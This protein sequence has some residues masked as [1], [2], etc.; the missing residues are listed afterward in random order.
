MYPA[1]L[2]ALCVICQDVT[3][4]PEATAYAGGTCT[5]PDDTQHAI[6]LKLNSTL[7]NYTSHFANI[8][9]VG[10]N[11]WLE[12]VVVSHPIYVRGEEATNVS[13]KNVTCTTCPATVV[14]TGAATNRHGAVPVNMNLTEV[15]GHTFSV[16][17]A[18]TIGLVT[19]DVLSDPIIVQ[20]V[21][22][23]V[24]EVVGCNTTD[25]GVLLSL[26]GD[27]YVLNFFD[28]PP[29]KIGGLVFAVKIM[30]VVTVSLLI[31]AYLSVYHLWQE[32]KHGRKLHQA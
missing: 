28:G 14:V 21:G 19:C 20:P 4:F 30:T 6:T 16:A 9:V 5:R 15:Y 23:A 29:H 2:G 7:T 26:Y 13:F 10:N 32:A 3:V 8:E 18:H 1:C 11:V 22:S 24:T 25:L 31:V 27:S 17:L 12:N